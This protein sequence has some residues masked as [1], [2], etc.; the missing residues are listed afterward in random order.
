MVFGLGVSN[1]EGGWMTGVFNLLVMFVLFFFIFRIQ[2]YQIIARLEKVAVEFEGMVEKS[3]AKV[4]R[5]CLKK[6]AKRKDVKKYVDS[7]A[8]FFVIP[9]LDTDPYGIMDKIEHLLNSSEDRFEEAAKII[10][11]SDD[12]E[13]LADIAMALKGVIGLN[14]LAKVVRHAVELAK[15]MKNF[16]IALII[17]MQ[18]PLLKRMAKGQEGGTK[19][20]LDRFPIGDGIGPYVA[21]TYIEKEPKKITDDVV[22][23]KKVIEG[24]NVYVVK[25]TGPG[26]RVGRPGTG[27]ERLLKKHKIT[28]VITVDAAGK[29]EG[30]TTGSVAEGVGVA[31]GG[32]ANPERVRIEETCVKMKIPIDAIAIKMGIEEAI[33]PMNMKILNS[34][35][36]VRESVLVS[37]GR[38]KKGSNVLLVGVGN[39][40]GVGDTK[41]E[42]KGIAEMVKKSDA[43][44]KKKREK[45]RKKGLNR[46]FMRKV[47]DDDDMMISAY[48]IPE[49]VNYMLIAQSFLYKL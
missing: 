11:P 37:L 29:L 5:K 14:Q 24:R 31:M 13:D 18:M 2:M 35:P 19:A 8:N 4:V 10:M 23:I 44:R 28:R 12:P 1:Q 16:Q 36:T 46:I 22:Y 25:A 38:T 17:Q 26:A 49:F 21:A 47:K 40:V 42:L 15:K 30:E 32:G 27:I 33:M 9:P 20:F 45:E 34:V 43:K 41:K 3:K 7:F 39:T 6:G 48:K